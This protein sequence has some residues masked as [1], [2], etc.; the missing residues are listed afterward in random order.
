MTYVSHLEVDTT[1]ERFPADA[2]MNNPDTE[3]GLLEVRYD[4]DRL[5]AERSRDDFARGPWSL[6]RYADLLPARDPAN[7]VTLGEGMTP[8]LPAPRLGAALGCGDLWIKDEGQN[9]SGSFKDRGAAVAATCLREHGLKTLIHNSSGNAAGAWGLYAARAGITCVNLVPDD[10]LEPSLKQSVLS[11]APTFRVERP[12]QEAG[13]MVRAAVEKHGWFGI[14]TLKEP[15]R[16]E[17]KKTMGLEIAEQFGWSFPDVIFYPTGGALGAIAIFKAFRELEALGWVDPA[18]RPRL[19]VT[20]YSGCSPI[21][22][23]FDDGTDRADPWEKIDIPRGGLKSAIPPGDRA[24]LRIIRET[25]G[26]A[27]AVS[28]DEALDAAMQITRIEGVFACPEAG[29]TLAALHKALESGAVSAKERILLM[30]TGSGLKSL[31]NFPDPAP[32]PITSA[33]EIVL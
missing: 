8:M 1:G 7:P 31:P 2:P 12:W 33:E 13:P 11:G 27:I 32:V 5:K 14:Q 16:L 22:K 9:P 25:G 30:N 20:Q 24:A 21:V 17:G 3:G 10:V 4:L 29:T 28:G 6:W 18:R 19:V 23:A 15:Y 26:T